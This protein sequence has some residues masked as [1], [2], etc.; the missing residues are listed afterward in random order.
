MNIAKLCIAVL[1]GFVLGAF[2]Y[3]PA[4]VKA[5][6]GGLIYVKKVSEGQNLDPMATNREVVGFSCVAARSGELDACYVAAR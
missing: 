6:G 4:N 3:R 2:V 1:I 5:A